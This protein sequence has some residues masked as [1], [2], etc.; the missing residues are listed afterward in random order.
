MAIW[1]FHFA[2]IAR[3][4]A[5]RSCEETVFPDTKSMPKVNALKSLQ[6]F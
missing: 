1:T 2:S 5:E 6:V 3:P 4:A